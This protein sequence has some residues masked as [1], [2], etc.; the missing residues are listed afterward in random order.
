MSLGLLCHRRPWLEAEYGFAL[1]S[2][3]LDVKQ[4]V[5]EALEETVP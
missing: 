2:T 4:R 1:N 5:F 3:L